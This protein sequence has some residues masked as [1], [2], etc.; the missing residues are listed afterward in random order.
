MAEAKRD[1]EAAEAAGGTVVEEVGPAL[2]LGSG[3]VKLTYLG[4]SDVFD[5]GP[6][7]E[8]DERHVLA[9][10]GGPAVDVPKDVADSVKNLPYDKFQE[11]E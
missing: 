5:F 7:G 10:A 3:G 2:K 11:T 1:A 8:D 4:T 6:A 9:V